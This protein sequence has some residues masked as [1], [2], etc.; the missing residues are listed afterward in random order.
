MAAYIDLNPVRAG[1]VEDPKNYR[2]C[3]YAEAVVGH[4]AARRGSVLFGQTTRRK[5]RGCWSD[6]WARFGVGEAEDVVA[7]LVST[8]ESPPGAVVEAADA[9]A[10]ADTREAVV[11]N[12]G[13]GFCCGWWFC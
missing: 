6:S 2:F 1:L 10:A 3:G 11:V 12:T 8:G 13:W 9:R 4:A 5:L 7:G